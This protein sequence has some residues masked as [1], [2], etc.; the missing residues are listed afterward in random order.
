MLDREEG[1]QYNRGCQVRVCVYLT[2]IQKYVRQSLADVAQLVEQPFRKWQVQGFE[3]PHRLFIFHTL[4]P[5]AHSST[6]YFSSQSILTYL[7]SS[8]QYPRGQ[9]RLY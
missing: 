4:A 2:S 6:V 7:L 5:N 9:G 3:P 1:R 8:L